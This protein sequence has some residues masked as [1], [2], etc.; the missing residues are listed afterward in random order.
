MSPGWVFLYDGHCR[1]CVGS[2]ARMRSLTRRGVL[3]LRDFQKPGVLA[4]YPALTLDQCMRQAQL[5]APD[6]RVFEG[7][8][9]VVRALMT[10][11]VL[12][13]FA[14]LYYVPGIRQA[15]N[16]F[17]AWIAANR[18]QLFGR[19][20]AGV[21]DDEACAVHLGANRNSPSAARGPETGL[22]PPP[23]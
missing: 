10:R 11:S 21:C 8:E 12:G 17:Y 1:F 9:A 3:T 2:A 6:G 16:A 5:V 19:T 14:R 7:M 15:A 22:T 18:Y 4:E 23:R 13:A 20:A